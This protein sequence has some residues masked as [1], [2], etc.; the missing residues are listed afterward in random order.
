[1][2]KGNTSFDGNEIIGKIRRIRGDSSKLEQPSGCGQLGTVPS[3]YLAPELEFLGFNWNGLLVWTRSLVENG[4]MSQEWQ[5]LARNAACGHDF[6]AQVW[7]LPSPESDSQSEVCGNSPLQ[8][9]FP[10]DWKA[11]HGWMMMD[12]GYIWLYDISHLNLCS[13]RSSVPTRFFSAI[14]WR[15]I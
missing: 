4:R 11:M 7:L 12:N 14:S 13:D 9:D 6:T 8:I 10:W 15:G 1:M 3:C 5:G 2:G